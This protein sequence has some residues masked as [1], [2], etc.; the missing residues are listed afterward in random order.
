[1][2]HTEDGD[3]RILDPRILILLDEVLHPLEDAGVG[4]RRL[5]TGGEDEERNT[6][7]GNGDKSRIHLCKA[8]RDVSLTVDCILSARATDRMVMDASFD[9]PIRNRWNRDGKNRGNG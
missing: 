9:R 4:R 7:Q 6:H 1:M 8:R 2:V 3:A 5:G